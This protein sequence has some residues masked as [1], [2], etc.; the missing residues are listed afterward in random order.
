MDVIGNGDLTVDLAAPETDI[1]PGQSEDFV[2]T[3]TAEEEVPG[4][5]DLTV[6]LPEGYTVSTDDSGS[7]GAQRAVQSETAA[8]PSMAVTAATTMTLESIPAGQSAVAI[9][10][11]APEDAS[12][13][14]TV[15]ADLI[16]GE[17]DWWDDNPLPITHTFEATAQIGQEAN[18]A[19]SADGSADGSSEDGAADAAGG[20]EG[21]SG[22]V[23]ASGADTGSNGADTGSNGANADD[24]GAASANADGGEADAAGGKDGGDLPR[25]GFEALNLVAAALALIVAGSLAVTMVRRRRAAV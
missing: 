15:E 20:A 4:P 6:D 13:E 18:A 9:N 5:V 8:A 22:D 12:G 25:T 24:S 2:L 17:A 14:V 11:T 3:A 1:E 21:G 10:V 19:V 16:S 23:D 7:Q